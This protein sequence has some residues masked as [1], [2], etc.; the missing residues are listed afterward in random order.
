MRALSCRIFN[1]FFI[2]ELTRKDIEYGPSNPSI[3]AWNRK[4]YR[5]FRCYERNTD[6]PIE[7]N[8]ERNENYY[9]AHPQFMKFSDVLRNYGLFRDEHRDFNE[10]MKRIAISRGKKQYVPR[11]PKNKLKT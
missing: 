5:D 11:G 7:S 10:E 1:E 2:P 3:L 9:P 4:W 8:N 6:L